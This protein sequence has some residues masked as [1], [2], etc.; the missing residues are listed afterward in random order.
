M[1]YVSKDSHLIDEQIALL[2]G[3]VASL[4][5]SQMKTTTSVLYV[6][7]YTLPSGQVMNDVVSLVQPK[8]IPNVLKS[9]NDWYRSVRDIANEN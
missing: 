8:H 7:A 3:K 6:I 5:I 2:K 1:T 4:G 9:L